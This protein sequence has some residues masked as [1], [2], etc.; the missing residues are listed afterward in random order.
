MHVP[1]EKNG[2][3]VWCLSLGVIGIGILALC[4][5][6]F[7]AL[8]YLQANGRPRIL[9]HDSE[10]GW[11]N[12]PNFSGSLRRGDGAFWDVTIDQEGHRRLYTNTSTETQH[13]VV[14]GDSFTFGDSIGSDEHFLSIMAKRIG[15]EIV[16]LGVVGYSTDQELITFQRYKGKCDVLVLMSYLGNDLR[17]NISHFEPGGLR[18]KPRYR[19]DDG[20]MVYEASL[21]PFINRL[22]HTSYLATAL[23]RVGFEWFPTL[24]VFDAVDHDQIT[25]QSGDIYIKLVQSILDEARKREVSKVIIFVWSGMAKMDDSWVVDRLQKAKG[26]LGYQVIDLDR[27]FLERAVKMKDAYFSAEIDPGLHWNAKGHSLV[28]GILE[29]ALRQSR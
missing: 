13:I 11:A 9:E 24:S 20:A 25:S 19:E 14:L 8:S 22:R 12:R 26:S 15:G 18:F 17:D 3:P 21:H 23:L 28:A 6:E 7:A 16:N 2:V 1:S 27:V 10:L 29:D 4:F 5:V